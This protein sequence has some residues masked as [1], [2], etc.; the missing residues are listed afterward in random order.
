MAFTRQTKRKMHRR[1][2]EDIASGRRTREEV[3]QENSVF[4]H[5]ICQTAI[6]HPEDPEGL[7]R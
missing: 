1:D 2:A 3:P 4:P 5:E 6:L 7:A